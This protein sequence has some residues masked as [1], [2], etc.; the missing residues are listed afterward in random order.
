M[1]YPLIIFGAGASFDYIHPRQASGVLEGF[2]PPVTD[3]LFRRNFNDIM[4][5][6]VEMGDLPGTV[7]TVVTSGGNLE[8]L[9]SEL[10]L[11]TPQNPD[12][13][14]EL[15]A[16]R[17]YLQKLF[18]EISE[19]YGNRPPNNYNGL[20]GIIKDNFKEACIVNFNYDLLLEEALRI[21]GSIKSY[22]D[23]SIKVIK[24]HG[25]CDWV[26]CFK[27]P[28]EIDDKDLMEPYDFLVANPD[29][30]DK[31]ATKI[32]RDKYVM[33]DCIERE[34]KEVRNNE[35]IYYYPAIALPLPH[36]DSFLCPNSHVDELE[37]AMQQTDRI[38]IIGWKAGD[39][40]LIEMMKQHITKETPVAIVAGHQEDC[41]FIKDKLTDLPFVFEIERIGFSNF[42]GSSDCNKFFAAN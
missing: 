30:F 12:R 41:N 14:K 2:K 34:Y 18:Q 19:N 6:F 38:A 10:V 39:S 5:N 13:K 23:D 7:E 29:Y 1:S 21:G 26:Y 20:I 8:E 28:Y 40:K 36:K 24:V 35:L 31:L 25:S 4:N 3:D 15:V 27:P 17:F 9:L 22:V 33:K 42:V 37:K 32:D 16:F 11:K